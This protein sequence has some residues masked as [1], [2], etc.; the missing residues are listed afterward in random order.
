LKSRGYFQS[1]LVINAAGGTETLSMKIG[2]DKKDAGI[3]AQGGDG[4]GGG[5]GGILVRVGFGDYE[6][7]LLK[8]EELKSEIDRRGIRASAIDLRFANRVVVTPIAEVSK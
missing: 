6:Q 7:K 2:S 5:G 3:D 8:L 1:P 4:E